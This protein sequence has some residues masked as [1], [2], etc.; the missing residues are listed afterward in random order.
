MRQIYRESVHPSGPLSNRE[1]LKEPVLVHLT[2]T[3]S[4][5]PLPLELLITKLGEHPDRA[6]RKK[7]VN[8]VKSAKQERRE[9][10]QNK[11][12]L[13]VD[14][15][16]LVAQYEAGASIASLAREFGVHP[17]T[18]DTHLKR[19]GVE[20][21]G[22]FRLSRQQNEMAVK[23]Y[24]DG[25]STIEIAKEFGISTNAARLT[26]IRAGVTLR[27]SQE[28]RWHTDRKTSRRKEK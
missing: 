16:K 25:W 21:R 17:Q 10:K 26:L 4:S 18:V 2:G 14:V 8:K 19:Q 9:Y 15:Q 24:A 11:R 12:L 7:L 28:G 20:K 27:S 1:G 3:L 22:A 23:L 6:P 5:L 13:P